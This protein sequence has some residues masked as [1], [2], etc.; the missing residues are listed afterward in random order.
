MVKKSEKIIEKV[1][2]TKA[3]V[4]EAVVLEIKDPLENEEKDEKAA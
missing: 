1:E 3:T 4:E 2:E